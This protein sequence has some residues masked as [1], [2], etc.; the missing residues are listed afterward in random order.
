MK[1]VKKLAFTSRSVTF[2]WHGAMLLLDND[3]ELMLQLLYHFIITTQ[4]FTG[5]F[6]QYLLCCYFNIK[7][8][9]LTVPHLSR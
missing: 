6:L 9:A 3:G 1:L 5:T 8:V 7:L 2:V 4:I